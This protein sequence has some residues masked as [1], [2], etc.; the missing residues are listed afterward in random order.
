MNPEGRD[1]QAAG[2]RGLLGALEG[3]EI[4]GDAEREDPV[5]PDLVEDVR[6]DGVGVMVQ[7][8]MGVEQPHGSKEYTTGGV[9]FSLTV[10]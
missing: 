6:H 4:H 2:P 9:G 7:M 10:N 5:N 1:H 3:G 8:R